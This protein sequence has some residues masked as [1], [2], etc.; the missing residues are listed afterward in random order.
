[1]EQQKPK[2]EAKGLRVAALS[3]DSPA[4]LADFARR[5]GITY[6]LLADSGSRVIRAFNLLNEN[7]PK[8]HPW[9]GVPFPGTFIID[10]KGVITAKYFESDHRDRYTA[11]GIFSKTFSSGG[12][13]AW[14]TVET[15][16]LTVRYSASDQTV[17]AGS[18]LELMV[19]LNLK[20]KFHVYA[21]G[22]QASYKPIA[23]TMDDSTAWRAHAIA[24]P[25]SRILRLEAIDESV[26]VFEGSFRL[27]RDL[28]IGQGAEVRP[29]LTGGNELVIKGALKYQACDDRECY[30]PVSIPLEWRFRYESHDNERAP[31]ELQRKPS[32]GN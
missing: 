27:S 10:G 22:V 20:S 17:K 28:S 26:P 13:D 16:H 30:P 18:R 9:F 3:Y 23:W 29:A 14:S 19:E 6:P 15:P 11:A 2:F 12:G 7:F 1:M 24:F 4:L 25:A 8:D 5:R 32:D 21:P 31:A